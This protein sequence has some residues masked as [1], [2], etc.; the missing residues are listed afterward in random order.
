MQVFY[1][2]GAACLCAMLVLGT[3]RLLAAEQAP[4]AG[5]SLHVGKLV[6]TNLP[7]GD[8]FSKPDIVVRV[9]RQ[10]PN[11]WEAIHRLDD[12]IK[13][14]TG[15]QSDLGL[16]VRPLA[17]KKR[18]SEI[19]PGKPM[20]P[21]ESERLA[22]L[23]AEISNDCSKLPARLCRDCKPYDR[24]APCGLCISC[25]ELKDLRKRKAESEIRPGPPLTAAETRQLEDLRKR[26]KVLRDEIGSIKAERTGLLATVSRQTPSITTRLTTMHFGDVRL[27]TVFPGDVLAVMVLES[28]VGKDDFYD[29]TTTVVPMHDIG[30]GK[31]EL[32]SRKIRVL[33]LEYRP[34]GAQH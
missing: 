12:R 4:A 31:I 10:D 7:S 25:R 17:Q 32:R 33:E 14:M 11:T 27:I 30:T 2:I 23:D 26:Q 22:Q 18:K 8:W 21:G 1:R 24:T 16:A 6:L 15:K 9:E 3:L 20:T 29:V 34:L 19:E 28:D 5:Y 13:T